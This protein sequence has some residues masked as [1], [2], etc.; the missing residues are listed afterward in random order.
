MLPPWHNSITVRL[1]LAFAL[2][3]TLVFAALGIYLGRSADAHMAELDAHELHGKLALVRHVGTQETTPESMGQR[4]G[5]AM[6]GEHGLIV[7][8]DGDSGSIFRWPEDGLAGELAATRNIGETPVRLNLNGRDFRIVAGPLTTAWGQTARV[9][10]ARDIRHHTAFLDR[11][12]RDFWLALL[13]AA[14]LTVTVGIL[15]ARRGMAPVRDIAHAAGRISAGQLAERIPENDVPLELAELVTAFNAMLGRLEES[16]N[17]LSDFS[18]NLAH[19]L[20]TPLHT[21][22]MQTEVSLGKLRSVDEYRELLASNL[23]EYERLSRII[24][25]MLF[26]AKADNGLVMPQKEAVD[27]H[28]LCRHLLEYYGILAD[29]LTLTLDGEALTVQGDRLM[30]QRAIG[31]LLVNAIAHTPPHGGVTL[32]IGEQDGMGVV[33]ISNTGSP[34]P[35]EALL[36]I[37][38]RFVRLD[39]GREGSG[40]G[41]AI[42][43][44]IV[45]AHGGSIAAS[46]SDQATAFT[47]RLPLASASI[48]A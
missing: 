22:R 18:G 35:A 30:L 8:V 19:E 10:V 33:S 13:A 46:S 29:N 16:F 39:P 7:A 48:S 20:R 47:I 25:D 24:A 4:L 12:Q 37:F 36:R 27:L 41:L 40:L 6:V 28:D 45:L 34:I 1:S 38:D 43:R 44:S 14:L 26:L 21:L 32:A 42:T 5:D 9:V 31:N 3:A 17:R 23:E 2:L 15:I 11:L